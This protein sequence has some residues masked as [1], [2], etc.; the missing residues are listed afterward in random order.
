MVDTSQKI[1]LWTIEVFVTIVETKS[2]S[3][4]AERIGTSVSA[5]SQQLTSL[6]YILGSELLDRS[7]RPMRL[8]ATGQMFL[9]RARNMLGEMDQAKRE[10]AAFDQSQM[11]LLRLGVID[12][13]DVAITPRL[14]TTLSKKMPDFRFLL[15]SGAS[16]DLM[17]ELQRKSL[18]VIV[19]ADVDVTSDQLES[20]ELMVEPMIVAAP[21]GMTE[22]QI[23]KNPYIR[24]STREMLGRQIEANLQRSQIDLPNLFELNSYHA[25]L[26]LVAEGRGWTITNPMGCMRARGL[27]D[28]ITL[29][30]VPFARMERKI[31]LVARSGE[32]D[33]IPSEIVSILRPLLAAQMIDPILD[34]MPWLKGKLTLS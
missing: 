16:H 13:F 9:R 31:H 11:Q 6:E 34:A 3:A 1:S 24:H 33:A 30:P 19:A 22:N 32:L 28:Q 10:L 17:A 7:T 4:A 21:K 5:V 27:M 15:Q 23:L 29:L 8:T 12:D 20:H 26:S 2:L 25:I 14:M 18:D